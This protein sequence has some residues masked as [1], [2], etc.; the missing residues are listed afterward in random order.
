MPE[1]EELH[2]VR[3]VISS[4]ANERRTLNFNGMSEEKVQDLIQTLN[5]AFGVIRA[6]NALM[7]SG[8][9]GVIT[10]ANLSNVAFVEVHI[11]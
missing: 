10:F 9:D 5:N 3:I 6:S 11:V 7:L 2:D 4:M 1:E 8:S